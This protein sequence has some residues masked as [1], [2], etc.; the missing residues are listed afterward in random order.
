MGD[1][2]LTKL[3]LTLATWDADTLGS[4]T[5]GTSPRTVE[6][7]GRIYE[8]LK[9]DSELVGCLNAAM[10][11]ATD[12]AVVVSRTFKP[13]YGRVMAERE[14]FYWQ[15]YADH[16]AGTRWDEDAI[17]ALDL[18]TTRIVERLA[19]PERK[20]AYQA[21]GLVVGYVQSGKTANFTGVRCEGDRRWLPARHR[22]DGNDRPASRTDAAS[23]RQGTRRCR[24]PH[25]RHR[26]RRR[27]GAADRRLPR[28]SRLEQHSFGMGPCRPRWEFRTSTG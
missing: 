11:V 16:L 20:E 25:A 28:R 17:A 10:P 7:R 19:D 22:P 4:W 1:R 6:R 23:T 15:H 8:L 27:R 3:R 24:E 2:L 26:P 18:N 9:V 12:E 21:K 13:W 5:D 14:P